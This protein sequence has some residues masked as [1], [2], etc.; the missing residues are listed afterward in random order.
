MQ[1]TPSA[2]MLRTKAKQQAVRPK[3]G[4]LTKVNKSPIIVAIIVP[5]AVSKLLGSAV[6]LFPSQVWAPV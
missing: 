3:Y 2:K 1:I 5:S 4:L 6:E